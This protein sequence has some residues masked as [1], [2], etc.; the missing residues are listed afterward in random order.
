MLSYVFLAEL[1]LI[2]VS[3]VVL[4][5][6]SGVPSHIPRVVFLLICLVGAVAGLHPNFLSFS[7]AERRDGENVSG[8]HPNCS[9]YRGHSVKVLDFIRC[10]GCTGLV[11]G[12][13]LS[14]LGLGVGVS[15]LWFGAEFSFWCGVLFVS[16][17]LAQHFIDLGSGWI[18]LLLNTIFV[19]GAWIIFESIQ[20]LNL[21]TSVQAYFLT[22]TIFWIWA[23]IRSSQWNHVYICR[24][25]PTPCEL[26][27]E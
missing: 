26:L 7:K 19:I 15:P 3:M 9:Y 10:A 21:T 25:C 8:H 5:G 27:F 23:R 18:H 1:N 12:A 24:E 14:L 20:V 6:K 16:L 22:S 4:N 2:V 13:I 11:F 17:G